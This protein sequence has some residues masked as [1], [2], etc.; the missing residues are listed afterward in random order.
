MGPKGMCSLSCSREEICGLAVDGVNA[1]QVLKP[2]QSLQTVYVKF[3]PILWIDIEC[4]IG[5]LISYLDSL[6]M[7]TSVEPVFP[8]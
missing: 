3:A 4:L 8:R 7:A 6:D 1:V 2:S 5:R